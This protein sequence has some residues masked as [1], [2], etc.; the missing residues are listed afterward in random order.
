MNKMYGS[1]TIT[2]DPRDK[3]IGQEEIAPGVYAVST[4]AHIGIIIK[5]PRA[6][7]VLSEKA[8][9]IGTEWHDCYAFEGD[10]E[11]AVVRF[12]H[13]EFF[14]TTDTATI[15]QQAEQAVRRWY[16]HYFAA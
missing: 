5:K 3:V 16:P 8:L 1:R 12:E 15:K 6:Q 13:P 10:C 4:L 11:S 9:A 2:D 14:S 7:Q